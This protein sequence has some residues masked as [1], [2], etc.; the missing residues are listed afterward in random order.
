MQA[1]QESLDPGN[2]SGVHFVG[3]PAGDFV[4]ELDLLFD[5]TALV[6]NKRATRFAIV[7][8]DGKVEKVEVEPDP[9][10]VTVTSADTI[11]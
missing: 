4:N 3:D 6:G 11:L 7:V 2:E 8:K 10:K 9:T 1:W 5:A